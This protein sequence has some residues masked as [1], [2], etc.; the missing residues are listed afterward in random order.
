[1][2]GQIVLVDA[3]ILEGIPRRA[4]GKLGLLGHEDPLRAAQLA[5]EL[6]LWDQSGQCRPEAELLPDSVK[7]NPG[8]AVVQ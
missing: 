2:G 4:V 7:H 8:P 5:F 6:R 3:G 1:M